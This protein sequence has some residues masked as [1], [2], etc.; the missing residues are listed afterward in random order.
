MRQDRWFFKSQN[1]HHPRR[2]VGDGMDG[3]RRPGTIGVSDIDSQHAMD[4]VHAEEEEV[5]ESF[6]AERPDGAL[7]LGRA[8]GAL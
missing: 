7:E 8:V 2:L 5:V 6:L 1:G 4:V 3:L